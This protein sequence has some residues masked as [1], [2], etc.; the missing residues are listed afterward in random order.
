MLKGN[1]Q[2]SLD[3]KDQSMHME[4]I[5]KINYGHDFTKLC[6][7]KIFIVL[8]KI[9]FAISLKHSSFWTS[10]DVKHT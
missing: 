9:L 6:T 2:V 5:T 7:Y 8:I 4:R 3:H 1:L 10:A